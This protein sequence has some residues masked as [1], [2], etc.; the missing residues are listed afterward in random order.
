MRKSIPN[1]LLATTALA[2]ALA[3]TAHPAAALPV[4]FGGSVQ[5]GGQSGTISNVEPGQTVTATE[6]LQLQAPD[7]SIVTIEPG[8][9]FVLT[10]EGDNISFELVSGAMRIA[11]SGTPISI[12]RNGVT[13]VT[14]GGAFSAFGGEDGGLEGRV[15]QGKVM[16]ENAGG[17]REFASGE[18]YVASGTDI[19]G[20]FTPPA[21]NAPQYAQLGTADADYSPADVQGSEGAA[22][23]EQAGGGSSGYGGTPPV[24]G[25]IVPVTGTE[26]SGYVIAYAADSIGIDA[27]SPGTVTIG[28]GGELNEYDVTPGYEE[29]LERNSNDSLERGNS[30]GNIFIERWAGGET[31]G[32][33]Y[34]S[35]NGTTFSNLGRTSHQGFHVLYGQP[36]PEANLPASGVATYTLVAATNPTMD[37]GRYAPGT[38]DGEIGIAFGPA[39]NV[40][41][42]FTVDMPGDHVYVIQTPGGAAAPSLVPQYTDLSQGVFGAYNIAVPQG[43]DACPTSACGAMIYGLLAGNAGEDLGIVYRIQDFSA[44][45]DDLYRGT[46]IS[47]A[48]VFTQTP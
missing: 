20:T 16:V 15:N 34:N 35:F 46:Q 41:V 40:G 33:Y 28:A 21:A 47:G 48:A 19:A 22:I 39:F 27:R 1:R 24:T 14:S 29:R 6:L 13:I 12:S 26:Y 42:D 43:G 17:D 10:G 37:N 23:A 9:V 36:T 3:F 11:S 30:N 32:D 25:V 5:I 4:L 31:N 18:G 7:G 8:S 45:V 38:F 2:G 44:P